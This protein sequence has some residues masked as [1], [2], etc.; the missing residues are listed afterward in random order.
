MNF[1][2][3]FKIPVIVAVVIAALIATA[4]VA[5]VPAA[6]NT[7]ITAHVPAARSDST[8]MQEKKIS[9]FYYGFNKDW[10]KQNKKYML[11]K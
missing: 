2:F 1:K 10:I 4:R 11:R 5:D 6:T 9:F 8:K 7:A 3:C